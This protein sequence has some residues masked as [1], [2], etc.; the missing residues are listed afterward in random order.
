MR[1][2]STHHLHIITNE[3]SFNL[4]GTLQHGINSNVRTSSTNTSTK[5]KV[6]MLCKNLERRSKGSLNASLPLKVIGVRRK[7]RRIKVKAGFVVRSKAATIP[8][9]G[10]GSIEYLI[11]LIYFWLI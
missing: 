11:A 6:E 5:Y 9:D 4:L 7:K 3:H 8:L 1:T 10:E 2:G